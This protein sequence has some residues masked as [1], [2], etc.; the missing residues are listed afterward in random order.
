MKKILLFGATGSI[1]LNTIEI[2]QKYSDRYQIVGFS[3]Y[4]NLQKAYHIK[5]LFPKAKVFSIIETELNTVDSY[6]K[7][8]DETCP[9]LIV[10]AIIGFA[11]ID[12]SLLA[13][14]NKID[15]ALANKETI[16]IC[17]NLFLEKVEKSKINLFPIDSE[18]SALYQILKDIDKNNIKNLYITASGGKYYFQKL[19]DL[20]N[21]TYNQVIDHPLWKMGERISI[22]S[23]TMI[24]KFFE[25]IEVH[26]YFKKDVKVLYHPN[27]IIHAGVQKKDN[28]YLFNFSKPDMKHAILLALNN[29]QEDLE[30]IEPLDFLKNSLILNEIDDN[31]F[32]P[33]KWAKIFME[34]KYLA[35][36]VIVNAADE[37]LIML[38][39]N[40]KIKFNQIVTIIDDL[41]KK[42]CKEKINSIEN[43]KKLDLE[44]R[45]L[46]KGEF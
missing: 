32:I 16:A 28:S 18:H 36:P 33:L 40:N 39:K 41:I 5:K 20:E 11:G 38:F 19:I 46:I 3:F 30:I 8:I 43:I 26:Y 15:L 14:E 21:E 10:N 31:S 1:G 34:K 4:K 42:Y 12:I 27:G 17:G 7:L 24:N 2:V 29:Y 37:E 22:D 35:I 25:I 45:D 9:D 6:Q 23:S 13:V 44:I